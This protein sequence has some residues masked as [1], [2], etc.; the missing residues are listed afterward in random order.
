MV[1][2]G[3]VQ[4]VVGISARRGLMNDLIETSAVSAVGRLH[5]YGAWRRYLIHSR[6]LLDRGL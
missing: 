2:S 4:A 6:S 3:M 5:V 1:V